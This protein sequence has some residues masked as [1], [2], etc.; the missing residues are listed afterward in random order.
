MLVFAK[1]KPTQWDSAQRIK[2]RREKNCAIEDDLLGCTFDGTAVVGKDVEAHVD[3][4]EYQF[5]TTEPG[6]TVKT[7]IIG[8]E[9]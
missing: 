1:Y 9:G 5:N 8:E 4:F 2:Q 3:D 6:P 7:A